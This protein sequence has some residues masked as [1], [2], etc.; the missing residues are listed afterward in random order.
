[1]F[2]SL[3]GN[4]PKRKAKSWHEY[5]YFDLL[6]RPRL[7]PSDRTGER[8]F[9]NSIQTCLDK[10]R[11]LGVFKKVT[12]PHRRQLAALLLDFQ[13][14]EE[15]FQSLQRNLREA[16]R[17]PLG[18]RKQNKIA[19]LSE[20]V[21]SLEA[22]FPDENAYT[23]SLES[24]EFAN[25]LEDILARWPLKNKAEVN[26]YTDWVREHHPEA[27][28]PTPDATC[29]LYWFLV[30][31]CHLSKKD[32]EIRVAKIGNRFLGWNISLREKYGGED[33]W[34]GSTAIRQRIATRCP[35]RQA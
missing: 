26:S 30:C 8:A 4:L 25:H 17:A 9:F 12:A 1:M 3:R 10:L 32:A 7:R 15:M 19:K 5:D 6:I 16:R 34:R 22:G 24:E 28:D 35:E 21:R 23:L 20:E 27:Q 29:Q 18:K 33:S 14:R 13:A 11:R 2:D 31:K